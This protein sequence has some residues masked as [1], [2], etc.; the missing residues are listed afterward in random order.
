M[1]NYF[2]VKVAL[3]MKQ[4]IYNNYVTVYDRVFQLKYYLG[5]DVKF[6]EMVSGIEGTTSDHA[7]IWCKFLKN[8][9][10]GM[11][12][13]WSITDVNQGVRTGEQWKK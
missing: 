11:N 6:L 2:V 5:G 4:E 8:K 13:K 7:C 3:L 1:T 12:L 10:H 9:R